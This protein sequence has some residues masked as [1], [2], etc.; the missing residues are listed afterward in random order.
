VRGGGGFSP[1]ECIDMV[2]NPTQ[3]QHQMA[4]WG[5]SG[6]SATQKAPR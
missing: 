3:K 4:P 1:L 5:G 6:G 2:Y